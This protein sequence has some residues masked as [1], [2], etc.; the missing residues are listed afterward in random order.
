MPGAYP[1]GAYPTGA[2]YAPHSSRGKI[3]AMLVIG[4]LMTIALIGLRYRVGA[5][6]QAY[7]DIFDGARRTSL[8]SALQ[9]GDPGYEAINWAVGQYG[10]QVWMVNLVSGAIFGWGLLRFCA[11]QPRPWLAFCVAIPYLVIVVAMGYTRQAVALGVLM[12]G[13]ARQAKG[14]SPLNFSIYVALAA[15]FHSTAVVIFPI[16]AWSSRG[17]PVINAALLGSIGIVLYQFF[18][19]KNMDAYV[20]NYL[21]TAYSSQGAF[22]R[23]SMNIVAAGCFY[24]AGRRLEFE[25]HE[26]KIW[27][28]FSLAAVVMLVLLAVLPSSTAVDRVSLYLMPLQIAV[29][30]RLPLLSRNG[31]STAMGVILYLAA[32][33]FVWLNYAQFSKYWIPYQFYPF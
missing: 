15:T 9:L 12:A 14:A 23:V 17:S 1:V 10:A 30:S 5:D 18:L 31:A 27:R 4:T 7:V 24:I 29:I 3:S 28:N 8:S 33:E 21:D 13:L 32:V 26:Y 20:A 2:T 25:S 11:A 22:I 19:G 6:W 16:V